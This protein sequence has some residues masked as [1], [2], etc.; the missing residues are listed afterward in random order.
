MGQTFYYEDLN[1]SNYFPISAS[2]T[3]KN[4]YGKA[5]YYSHIRALNSLEAIE[6]ALKEGSTSKEKESDNW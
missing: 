4:S 6:K 5:L 3:Y 2:S 1:I